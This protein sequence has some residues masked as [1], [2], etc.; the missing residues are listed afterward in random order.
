L[1]DELERLEPDLI[2]G[3]LNVW[4]HSKSHTAEKV[5]NAIVLC[6]PHE[7]ILTKNF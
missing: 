3:V 7:K 4:D 6:F 2:E 1:I 5:A